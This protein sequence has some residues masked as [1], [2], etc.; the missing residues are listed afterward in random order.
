MSQYRFLQS[1]FLSVLK[2]RSVHI[3]N[4]RHLCIIWNLHNDYV[5]AQS[6]DYIERS[7]PQHTTFLTL[8]HGYKI[9]RKHKT[10]SRLVHF[11]CIVTS[12]KKMFLIKAHAWGRLNSSL[13]LASF[14]S[15]SFEGWTDLRTFSLHQRSLCEA[16]S[17]S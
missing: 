3:V 11:H 2:F 15:L 16:G 13:G 10:N 9:K 5:A 8:N 6:H 4:V 14:P 17:G 1:V 12:Q 7:M